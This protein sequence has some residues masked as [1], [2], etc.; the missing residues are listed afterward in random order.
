[1]LWQWDNKNM[2]AVLCSLQ[3]AR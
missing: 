3:S 2:S 1:M